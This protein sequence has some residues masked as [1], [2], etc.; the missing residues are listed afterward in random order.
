MKQLSIVL[1]ALVMVTSSSGCC[2]SWWPW[3][4]GY[5]Y[6]YGQQGCWGGRCPDPGQPGTLV[7]P[8]GAYY[9]TYGTVQSGLPVSAPSITALPPVSSN[10]P[11]TVLESLPTYR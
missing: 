9:N 3:G 4:M 2:C 8:S 7:T 5:G 11:T 1:L 6:Q 10:Y